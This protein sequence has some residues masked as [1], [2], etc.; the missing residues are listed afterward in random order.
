MISVTTN[1]CVSLGFLCAELTKHIVPLVCCSGTRNKIIGEVSKPF[2][3]AI[4]EAAA[5]NNISA[6]S[7]MLVETAGIYLIRRP[8]PHNGTVTA[9]TIFGIRKMISSNN[10]ITDPDSFLPKPSTESTNPAHT[11][12][13]YVMVYRASEAGT[14][15]KVVQGPSQMGNGLEP[16][17]LP[18]NQGKSLNWEVQE[19]D[20]IG[21]YIP[22]KCRITLGTATVICPSHINIKTNSCLSAFYH[23]GLNGIN[24]IPINEVQEVSLQLNIEA[25]LSPCKM[26]LT[27]TES[28]PQMK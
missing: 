3:D 7:D 25:V 9:V 12:F 27:Y 28:G 6:I 5:K 10:F 15:Y 11:L 8:I 13:L 1:A 18:S 22:R 2:R 17:R 14:V 4:F 19:G 23:P 20:L 16:G 26:L 24:D 21:V